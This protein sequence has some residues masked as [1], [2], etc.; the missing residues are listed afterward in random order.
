M[1][2][3]AIALAVLDLAPILFLFLGLFFLAQLVDRL[4]PRCRRMALC[5]LAFVILG[6]LAGAASNLS[7]AVLGE[8]IPL[9]AT[10]LHVFGAPGLTLLAASLIRSR[11]TASGRVVVR[12]PWI[13]PM[14]VTWVFLI[15][16]FYLNS[17]VGHEAWSRVLLVLEVGAGTAICAA[18]AALGW[19]RQLHMAAAMFAG[20]SAAIIMVAV[21]RLFTSQSVWIHMLVLLMTLAANAAF[22]FASWRVAAEY[23]ARVGPTA[24]T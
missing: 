12:D 4:D 8:E 11:S 9:L 15:A 18:A 2:L 19:K 21:L 22:A 14:F 3:L 13:A 5:G 10:I 17:S 1:Q 24:R 23:Q 16:A 20:N 7:L 6:A